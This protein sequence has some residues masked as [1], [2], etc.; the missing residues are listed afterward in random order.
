MV[1]TTTHELRTPLNGIM[2]LLECAMEDLGTQSRSTK[3]FLQPAYNCSALLLNLINDILDYSKQQ[4]N[5]SI[6]LSTSP[7]NLRMLI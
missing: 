1:A 2:G 6:T 7:T 4:M 3:K 5:R